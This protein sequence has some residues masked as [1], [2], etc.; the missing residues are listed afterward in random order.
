LK[1]NKA[2]NMP[3]F[4]LVSKNA[5]QLASKSSWASKLVNQTNSD[6]RNEPWHAGYD[7]KDVLNYKGA[8]TFVYCQNGLQ[9]NG[10]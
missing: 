6:Q 8:H 3:T 1:R 4:P 2:E 10:G 5:D 7:I 9:V